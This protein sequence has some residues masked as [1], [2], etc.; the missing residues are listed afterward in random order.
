MQEKYSKAY[1][2]FIPETFV[3][4]DQFNEF[5]TYFEMLENRIRNMSNG[6]ISL[7]SSVEG[8]Q[9]NNSNGNGKNVKRNLWIVKPS[10]SSRGRGIYIIENLKQVP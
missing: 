4:P 5:E 8:I 7:S 1:F 10:C 3:L 9:N 6:G 2:N